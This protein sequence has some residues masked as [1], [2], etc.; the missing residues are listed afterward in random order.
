MFFVPKRSQMSLYLKKI[1][2]LGKVIIETNL[3]NLYLS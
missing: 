2:T 1:Q 3:M